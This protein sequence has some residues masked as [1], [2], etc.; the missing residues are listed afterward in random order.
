MERKSSDFKYADYFEQDE[1]FDVLFFGTSHVINGIFPMELWNDYGIV[2]YNFGGHG[3]EIATSY[4]DNI[5]A[6]ID[7]RNKD[8]FKNTWIRSL[9]ENLGVDV[10]MLNEN[11]DFIIIKNGGEEA[12][13][14]DNFK[15]TESSTDTELGNIM[16]D[17]QE[18]SEKYSL[19]I[20]S[21]EYINAT[22]EDDTSM[23]ICVLRNGTV[24]DNVKFIYT[25][26][27]NTKDIDIS[28][29]QR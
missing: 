28:D 24:I 9:L 19:Y 14:M 10:N 23:Q 4:W 26:D 27:Q 25:I 21:I 22:I 18:D 11:T 6:V 5:D 17:Y 7:I 13:V 1:D 2:S 20:D 12:I 15:H 16:L 3:N 8:I 29:V